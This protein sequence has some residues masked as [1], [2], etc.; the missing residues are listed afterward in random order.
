MLFPREKTAG[1]VAKKSCKHFSALGL[2]VLFGRPILGSGRCRPVDGSHRPTAGG[3][4]N[5]VATARPAAAVRVQTVSF[6]GRHAGVRSG[7]YA[8]GVPATAAAGQP[9]HQRT[10]QPGQDERFDTAA[11][12][13]ADGRGQG[14][15]QLDKQRHQVWVCIAVVRG[16]PYADDSGLCAHVEHIMS[17]RLGDVAG[18]MKG[19]WWGGGG[20]EHKLNQVFL[21]FSWN[22]KSVREKKTIGGGGGWTPPKPPGYATARMET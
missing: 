18:I 1:N 11:R 5:A 13:I 3:A 21:Q 17:R 16:S 2:Q 10:D 20:F 8:T 7:W 4:W 6:A 22:H 12:P 19:W 15:G 9:D 14:E